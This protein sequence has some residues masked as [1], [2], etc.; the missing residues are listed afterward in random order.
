MMKEGGDPANIGYF[1]PDL[2]RNKA[3]GSSLSIPI[4]RT[5]E[6][7]PG[8]MV[9]AASALA[10]PFLTARWHSRIFPSGENAQLSG[11]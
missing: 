8:G 6:R 9:R 3:T 10:E 1:E 5:I 7:V 2:N 11:G 4:K